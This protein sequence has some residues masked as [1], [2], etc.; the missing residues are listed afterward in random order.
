MKKLENKISHGQADKQLVEK[1]Q[2]KPGDMLEKA[3]EVMMGCF[4]V[5][6]SDRL[7]ESEKVDSRLIIFTLMQPV[8]LWD[9]NKNNYYW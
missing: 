4:R 7:V 8:C 1:G 2:G 6:A 3:A 9:S 5:C